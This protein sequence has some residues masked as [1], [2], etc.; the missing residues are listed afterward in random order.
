MAKLKLTPSAGN[1]PLARAIKSGHG[2]YAIMLLQKGANVKHPVHFVNRTMTKNESTGKKEE[3]ELSRYSRSM[4]YEAVTRG[5]Q[6]V[7]YMVRSYLPDD[8]GLV[9]WPFSHPADFPLPDA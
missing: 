4:F 6:G 9:V 3:V 1:T 8:L 7:S 2:D 5:W